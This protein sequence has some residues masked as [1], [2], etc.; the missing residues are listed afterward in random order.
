MFGK[1]KSNLWLD[2]AIFIAFITTSMTGL[3]LWL[4][5]PEGAGSRSAILLGLTKESWI[6]I[7]NWAG[8]GMLMGA[9]IHILFHWKWI[10]CIGK[11][12]FKKLAKQARYNFSINTFLLI[13]FMI[14]NLSGLI[15][16]LLLGEGGYQGGR[17]PRFNT[18][19]FGLSRHEWNDIHLYTGLAITSILSLHIIN[20]SK[21][22]LLT[23]KRQ[24]TN[25]T[26][27]FSPKSIQPKAPAS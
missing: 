14:V 5:I 16:W 18:L 26:D 10:I 25:L 13:S 12:Y 15:I 3:L 27:Q 23:I 2:I 17:N 20:H 8:I 19:V 9:I 22:V 4:G 24:L 21:W 7:H 6:S 1:T 11:R